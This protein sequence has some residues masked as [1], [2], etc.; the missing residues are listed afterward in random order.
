MTTSHSWYVV[1]VDSSN[2]KTATYPLSDDTAGH[3]GPALR[4]Y[5]CRGDPTWSPGLLSM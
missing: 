4:G 3:S 5:V 2:Q 1:I